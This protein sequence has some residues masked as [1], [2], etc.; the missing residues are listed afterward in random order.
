M[1]VRNQTTN[2]PRLNRARSSGSVTTPPATPAISGP[3]AFS[4]TSS[5]ADSARRSAAQA[6]LLLH[7]AGVFADRTGDQAVVVVGRP[8][9]QVRQRGADRRLAGAHHA[10]QQDPVV[11][12]AAHRRPIGQ[13]ARRAA[14]GRP[15]STDSRP[16]TS[17]RTSSPSF[18]ARDSGASP[19]PVRRV[20]ENVPLVTSPR[21]TS[22]TERTGMCGR[23]MPRSSLREPPQQPRCADLLLAGQHVAAP[24]LRLGP[25]DGP[26]QPRLDRRDRDREVLAVQRVAHLGPQR[27]AGLPRPHGWPPI[28]PARVSSASR[29]PARRLRRWAAAHS[30]CSPVYPVRHTATGDPRRSTCS[31]AM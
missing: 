7:P 25:P 18:T 21:S 28:G 31:N 9:E 20:G 11:A 27:V 17:T 24:E 12:H 26:A 6:V 15:A 2:P 4:A 16:R 3:P 8:A 5:A 19:I 23:G 22:A 29:E 30:P 13:T 14:A 1:S 10:D